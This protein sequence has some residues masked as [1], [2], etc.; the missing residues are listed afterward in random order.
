M[1]CDVRVMTGMRKW[2]LR[3]FPTAGPVSGPVGP[4]AGIERRLGHVFT[5]RVA[6]E[7]ERHG[8]HVFTARV[9]RE[10]E[11]HGGHV[12]TARVA[13][14]AKGVMLGMS[15]ATLWRV[16]NTFHKVPIV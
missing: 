14:A 6:R 16:G 1:A 11:R 9:A 13:R 10:G 4:G 12:F 2:G 7:G 8:G 15:S 5:A 3:R